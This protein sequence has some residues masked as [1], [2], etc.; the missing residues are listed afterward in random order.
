MTEVPDEYDEDQ[1]ARIIPLNPD[2]DMAKEFYGYFW[3]RT[4][5]YAR[6]GKNGGYSH[7]E[8]LA[9]GS[10]SAFIFCVSVGII[11]NGFAVFTFFPE[12]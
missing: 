2:I 6:R 11:W 4:D 7:T 1:G 5:V 12:A 3:G 9:A 8:N 10:G